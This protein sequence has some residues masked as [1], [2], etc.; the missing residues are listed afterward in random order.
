LGIIQLT[1]QMILGRLEAL[2]V[3]MDAIDKSG[4]KDKV[5]PRPVE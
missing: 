2:D 4:H 5:P 1:A 3:L